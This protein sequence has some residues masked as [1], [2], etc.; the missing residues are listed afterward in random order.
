M[1]GR[2]SESQLYKESRARTQNWSAQCQYNVTEWNIMS[3]VWGMKFQWGSTLK[4]KTE[5][6]AT[7]RRLKDCWKRRKARYGSENTDFTATF[8][9]NLFMANELFHPPLWTGI[10]I[11]LVYCGRIDKKTNKKKKTT[12]VLNESTEDPEQ[13]SDHCSVR[14]G[15]TLGI[16]RFH[17]H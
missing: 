12:L 1:R 3:S 15:S 8:A 6:L 14:S 16:G 13:T 10:S 2:D 4:V 11:S 9:I 5:F 17:F 7:P